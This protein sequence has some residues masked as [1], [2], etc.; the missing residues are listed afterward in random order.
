MKPTPRRINRALGRR[1]RALLVAVAA[2]STCGGCRDSKAT[3]PAPVGVKVTS[4]IEQDVPIYR[5]W[6]GSTVGYV[7]AQ[8][9]ARVTGY[10]VS[11]NY[12]EGRVDRK[13]VVE[14]RTGD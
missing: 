8:I 6:V 7:T 12:Q 9:R 1:A 5:E 2:V 13:S 4:V 3:A 11:Q 14:G 10:L